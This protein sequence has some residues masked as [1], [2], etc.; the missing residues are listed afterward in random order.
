MRYA[1]HDLGDCGEGDTAVVR[2]QG[3]AANVILLDAGNFARYRAGETFLYEGGFYSRSPVE[4]EIPADGHWYVVVDT[5]GYKGRVRSSAD[6]RERA[7][8]GN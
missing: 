8:A 3:S 7:S 1:F 5:G 6:V 2:L 4:L